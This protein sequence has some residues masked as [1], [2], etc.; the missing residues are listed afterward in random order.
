M[1]LLS[2]GTHAH[3]IILAEKQMHGHTGSDLAK[4]VSNPFYIRGK[5]P[6]QNL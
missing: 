6:Q 1:E 2:A 3:M 4:G 5:R